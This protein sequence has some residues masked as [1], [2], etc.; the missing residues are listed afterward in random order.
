MSYSVPHVDHPDHPLRRPPP[1]YVCPCGSGLFRLDASGPQPHARLLLTCCRCR[2]AIADLPLASVIASPLP[3]EAAPPT[4][5]PP[6]SWPWLALL[7]QPGGEWQPIAKS[8]TLGG[9]WNAALSPW[10]RGDLVLVPV[11][12]DESTPKPPEEKQHRPRILTPE[13]MRAL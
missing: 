7:K 2:A 8:D 3:A 6:A 13:E 9:C 10:Q 12:P 5:P 4:K 1:G 11:R